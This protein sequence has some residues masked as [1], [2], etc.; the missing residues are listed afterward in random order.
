MT[1]RVTPL[2][3]ALG[4]AFGAAAC[5]DSETSPSPA[6]APRF[7][8]PLLPANEVPP[9]TNAEASGTGTATITINTTRD[10]SGNITAATADF[11]VS[12]SGFPGGTTLTNAHIHPGA[13]GVNGGVALGAGITSGEVVLSAAG[14]GGFTKTGITMDPA[15]AQAIINNPAGYYFNVHSALNPPGFARG[16]LVRS[17]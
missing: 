13:A 12:L 3:L 10:G 17:N 4:L 2:V 11:S 9:I 6:S 5:G 1:Y 7:T 8:A 14:A 15:L 16:Q